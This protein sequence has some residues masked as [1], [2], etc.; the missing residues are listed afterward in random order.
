MQ[1]ILT[2]FLNA[3]LLPIG[4]DDEKLKLLEAAAVDLAK[5]IKA[6]PPLVHRFT[7]VALDDRVP[8]SDPVYERTA[9][10]VLDKW[11]TITNKVG[12]SPV[13]V[14]RAVLLRAIQLASLENAAI[15]FAVTLV[16]RNL[17]EAPAGTA[18]AVEVVVSMLR[19]FDAICEAELEKIWV[20]TT[21]LSMPKPSSKPKKLTVGKEGLSAAMSRAVGP[22]D[23]GAKPIAGANPHW[24]NAGEPW[25]HEFV[26]RAV[27]GIAAAIENV[28]KSYIEESLATMREALQAVMP[29]LEGMAARDAKA[30]LLWIRASG[31]SPSAQMAFR[32]MTGASLVV[33]AALDVSRA[34]NGKTPASVEY[35]LRDLVNATGGTEKA[36][37]SDVLERT[38]SILPQQPE[39]QRLLASTLLPTTGRRGWIEIGVRQDAST[40]IETQTGVPESYEEDKAELA[41]NLFRELQILKLLGGL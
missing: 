31:Y 1:T 2:G 29:S 34:V 33:H 12:S 40:K 8:S 35:F 18:K 41:V 23:K 16:A 27:D 19:A 15:S 3:G 38:G 14:Y 10:A 5:G 39:G 20:V 28:F 21:D 30:E 24:P 36:R 6:T 26:E 11:A 22:N 37:L 13:N 4:E 7:L 25:A 17:R 32:D 9:D